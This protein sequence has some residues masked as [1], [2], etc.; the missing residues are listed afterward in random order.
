[1][2]GI[3]N[4]LAMRASWVTAVA[5]FATVKLLN[6]ETAPSNR[7]GLKFA[8]IRV[9]PSSVT[10]PVPRAVLAYAPILPPVTDVPPL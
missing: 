8:V 6:P 1:M 4:E 9:P 5:G 2:V 7:P 10:G 3:V